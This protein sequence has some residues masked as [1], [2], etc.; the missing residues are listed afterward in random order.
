M[1]LQTNKI[2]VF[3]YEWFVERRRRYFEA[4]IVVCGQDNVLA[5]IR[6]NTDNKIAEEELNRAREAAEAANIAKS[7]FLANM[8]HELRTPLN[9]ILGLSDLLLAEAEDSGYQDFLPD[10]NQIQ[11]SGVHLLTLIE[12]ILD[13]S[14][15]ESEIVNIYPERF[16]ISTL[17]S[18]VRSL[19]MPMI[20]KNDNN[21]VIE[22]SH[23]LGG[24]TSDRKRVKQILFN[25]LSNAAKFT[26][27]GEIT[28]S[29]M[30][31]AKNS[32]PA[33]IDSR[34]LSLLQKREQEDT[35]YQVNH[36]ASDWIIV[37]ISDTGIGMN[38]KQTK[39]VFQP[40]IQATS[41]Y[42]QTSNYCC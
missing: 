30:R 16:D 39:S 8:S 24:M 13:I 14:K 33:L 10:L 23:D 5:I 2:Y 26:H 34:Q 3:E 28:V 29:I 9:G 27:K 1:A 6:D 12:D 21:L 31:K 32:L 19:V 25:I 7:K 22:N 35:N 17:I 36:Q 18:E 41:Y 15:L 4:R 42:C 40:F 11:K 38:A 20:V 37:C